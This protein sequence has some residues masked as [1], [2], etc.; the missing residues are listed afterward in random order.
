MANLMSFWILRISFLRSMWKFLVFLTSS[1]SRLD[2]VALVTIGM[3]GASELLYKSFFEDA[4][5][6]CMREVKRWSFL[7]E[8]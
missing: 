1:A 7:L 5:A 6:R 4:S 2:G 3:I 8:S